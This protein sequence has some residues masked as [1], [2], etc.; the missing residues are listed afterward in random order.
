MLIHPEETKCVFCT[1]AK[2]EWRYDDHLVCE[3]CNRLIVKNERGKLALRIVGRPVV[4]ELIDHYGSIIDYAKR[5]DE[6][7]TRFFDDPLIQQRKPKVSNM[8]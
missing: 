5:A 8:K 4:A 3:A 7:I 1:T 6:Q 2:P